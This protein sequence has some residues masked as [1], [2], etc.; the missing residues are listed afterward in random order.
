M[1]KISSPRE[2]RKWSL[3]LGQHLVLSLLRLEMTFSQS[4]LLGTAPLYDEEA[5]PW[6]IC[7]FSKTKCQMPKKCP[8]GDVHAWN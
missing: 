6:G 3:G 2:Q 1:E 5:S 4:T 7:S 8:K